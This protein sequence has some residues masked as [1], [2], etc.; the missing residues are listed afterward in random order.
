MRI[1]FIIGFFPCIPETF[2][3]HQIAGLIACGHEVDIFAQD[4]GETSKV[5]PEVQKYNLINRTSYKISVPDNYFLR[6]IRGLKLIFTNFHKNRAVLFRSL[7]IFKYGRQA[8]SLRLLY[9]V[10]PFIQKKNNYDIIHCHFGPNGLL[11]ARL[12]DVGAIRG[13]LITTFHGFDVNL[14][15]TTHGTDLYKSLFAKCDLYTV[16]TTFT[17]GIAIM[18]G[19]PK[20]KIVRL[21]VGL[22]VSE[23]CF[24]A[25][26][27]RPNDTIRIL[28]VAR[29]VE[30]K[31]IQFSVRAVAKIIKD[32]PHL[33]YHIVGDG[34]LRKSIEML[35]E[36]LSL[37]DKV[38]LLGWRTQD[39][40]RQ[41]YADAHIFV[42][43]SVTTSDGDKE[44]Q[45]LVIQ[46]AQASGLPVISTLHN[47]IP[48]G[49][50]D[51]KSGFLVPE[52]D[53][54]ALAEKLIYLIEHP[55]IWPEMGRAGRAYVEA[56]YD[57][58][59]LND[60]LVEIYREFLDGKICSSKQR[61]EIVN[62]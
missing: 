6:V 15:P 4:K 28:T 44:G 2:I 45:G 29:L 25:K 17:A 57:I 49:I 50:L 32:Y 33:Q 22:K 39:E 5:H 52:R 18:L 21:P 47:G 54:D 60:R 37:Q 14:L 30:K 8:A 23:Y 11:G 62:G 36:Q 26:K 61:A 7:N 19:C 27:I 55:E 1:A 31:G 43:S 59:K 3:L 48:E 38:N 10:I 42:L 56:N 58:N 24:K 12:R 20:D 53:V 46:E 51:G 16:N 41:L 34:P 9:L 40:I 35:I 13:K